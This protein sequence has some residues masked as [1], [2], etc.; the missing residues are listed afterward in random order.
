MTRY[1]FARQIDSTIQMLLKNAI[2]K[3]SNPN[4]DRNRSQ[5]TIFLALQKKWQPVT[6]NN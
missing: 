3:P 1:S 5:P 2:M 6:G 4:N